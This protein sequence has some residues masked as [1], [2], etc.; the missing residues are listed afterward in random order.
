MS[1]RE[2]DV[3]FEGMPVHCYEGGAGFPLLLLH[4]SGAGTSSSSNWALVLEELSR[5]YHILAGDLIGFGR[6]ARKASQPYFDVELWTRQA[7][8]LLSRLSQG[9]P[10][11]FMGHSLSAFLGLRLAA[12]HPYLTK[13]VLTGCPA[14]GGTL[15]RALEVAWSFPDSVAKLREMY[16][17][18][19]ADPSGLSDDFYAQRL[20]VLEKPG[21]REYFSAMF[22]GDKRRYLDQ[23]VI[24]PEERVK[25]RADV[26]FIH[27][28][29][30]QMTPFA[31]SIPP[32]LQS[33][34]RA[35][36]YVLSHCGHGPALEQPA[37]F[38]HA[39][40]GLFG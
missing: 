14:S 17:Y 19:V 39:V 25:I 33:L 4:G 11:G 7:A 30:D 28:L 24:S 13:M 1:I 40:R 20:R 8:A 2:Y 36:A 23:L 3:E 21:Y 12:R 9:T 34:K 37:K 5:H 27:G 15:T 6:S 10:V 35:D 31:E 38:L 22:G 32:Y 18:V 26:L 16:G 29:Q